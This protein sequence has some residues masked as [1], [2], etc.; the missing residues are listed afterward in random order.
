MEPTG[1]RAEMERDDLRMEAEV[2]P[3]D[4]S[5]KALMVVAGPEA[6]HD[7]LALQKMAKG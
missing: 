3:L 2:E 7:C 6:R 1:R 5:T 4:L